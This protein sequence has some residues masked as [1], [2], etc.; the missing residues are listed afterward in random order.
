[1][2]T[3]Y[4]Y[5]GKT[6]EEFSVIMKKNAEKS[7]T[8]FISKIDLKGVDVEAVYSLDKDEDPIELIKETAARYNVDG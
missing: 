8:K 6:F 4:H 7:Y 1:M 3:G 2:P 5:T